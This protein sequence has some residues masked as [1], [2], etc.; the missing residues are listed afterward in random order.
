MIF[1]I[2]VIALVFMCCGWS[3]NWIKTILEPTWIPLPLGFPGN[4]L[5]KTIV[6]PEDII[7]RMEAWA[8]ETPCCEQNH[9][10][11]PWMFC[12]NLNQ[13]L[14]SGDLSWIWRNST[15]TF[16]TFISVW[17]KL[18][19]SENGSRRAHV[20]G[21]GSQGYLSPCPFEC[22]RFKWKGKLDKWQVLPFSLKCSPRILTFMVAPIVKF[23]RSR[24]I[25]LTA[26]MDNFTNQE[27]GGVRWSLRSMW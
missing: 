15:N 17:K 18:K 4:T 24:G 19:W 11:E 12:G 8:K 2:Y 7:T 13:H 10:G 16:V 14:T 6:L 5:E 9:P 20:Y 1:K 26:F 25:S 27:N 3:I 23:L 22:L 21:V